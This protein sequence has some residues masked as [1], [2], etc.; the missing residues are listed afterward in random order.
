MGAGTGGAGCSILCANE[1]RKEAVDESESKCDE[2]KMRSER[3]GSCEGE[4]GTFKCIIR[5]KREY[6]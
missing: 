6:I 4:G 1:A 5:V 2:T 3:K